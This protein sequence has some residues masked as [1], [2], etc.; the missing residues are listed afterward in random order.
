MKKRKIFLTILLIIGIVSLT[1]NILSADF[2]NLERDTYLNF[3]S[4]ILIIIT[5]ILGFRQKFEPK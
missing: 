4:N 3:L 2:N 1:I 5:A